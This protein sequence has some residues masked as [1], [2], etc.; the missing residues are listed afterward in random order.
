M[1]GDNFNFPSGMPSTSPGRCQ[2]NGPLGMD[3]NSTSVTVHSTEIDRLL[4][5]AYQ[6]LALMPEEL[7]ERVAEFLTPEAMAVIAGVAAIW[8]G[9]HFFGVG[10]VVD[11]V[12]AGAAIITVG[13]DA[14]K[15]LKG[16]V[17][18][19]NSAVDACSEE[20]IS[21]AARHFADATLTT[22]NLIGWANLAR[23]LARSAST[24][25]N[26]VRAKGALSPLGRWTRYINSIKFDIPRDQGMLWTKLG[27]EAQLI[28]RNEKL[29]TLEMQLK[30]NGFQKLYDQEFGKTQNS[31]T[32]EIWELISKKYVSSLKGRVTAY[33]DAPRHFK[34]KP[35][36][37]VAELHEIRKILLTNSQ[38]TEVVVI[39]KRAGELKTKGTFSDKDDDIAIYT[40]EILLSLIKLELR[41]PSPPRP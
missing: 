7:R 32:A 25:R 5:A 21:T 38:I 19:Y 10:F 23:F 13:M 1:A 29:Y 33:I 26:A 15:A 11:I 14:I 37:I 20:E 18:Y 34:E 8:A 17:K 6:S 39:N 22:A 12:F 16:Y 4:D 36:V 9:S 41:Q 30:K 3:R 24:A 2:T 27:A 28:A 35:G 40:R 31:T